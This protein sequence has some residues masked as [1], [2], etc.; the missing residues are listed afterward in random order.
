MKVESK[1]T[2]LP[3]V[4]LLAFW[5]YL[6]YSLFSATGRWEYGIAIMLAAVGGVAL[7][8]R[9]H[10]SRTV[11]YVGATVS[12]LAWIRSVVVAVVDG[13]GFESLLA[14]LFGLL[15]SAI[16]P[17]VAV[18]CCLFVALHYRPRSKSP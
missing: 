3:I 17:A 11:L 9:Q 1:P 8:L 2:V 16:P 4:A 14:A 12:V 13:L 7:V 6:H 10:W 18:A 5:L 15:I